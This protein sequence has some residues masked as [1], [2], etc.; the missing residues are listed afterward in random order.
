MSPKSHI[1]EMAEL[2]LGPRLSSGPFISA[3]LQRHPQIG[4]EVKSSG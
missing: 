4:F 1:M 3:K 2:G